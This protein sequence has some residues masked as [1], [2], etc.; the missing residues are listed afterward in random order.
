MF[1]SPIYLRASIID[2]I[3]YTGIDICYHPL[4]VIADGLTFV[5]TDQSPFHVATLGQ[6]IIMKVIDIS[7]IE[8]VFG[9]LDN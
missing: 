9:I 7:V 5:G 6:V 2:I 4:I 8:S 1:T 3:Y